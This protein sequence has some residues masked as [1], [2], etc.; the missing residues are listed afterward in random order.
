MP[1]LKHWLGY[2]ENPLGFD[3]FPRQIVTCLTNHVANAAMV[4]M[5]MR[6]IAVSNEKK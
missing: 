3:S 2:S 5:I 4:F 1:Y 6:F